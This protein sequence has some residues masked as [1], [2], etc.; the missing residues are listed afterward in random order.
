MTGLDI[1][2]QGDGI[3]GAQTRADVI[4]TEVTFSLCVFFFTNHLIS[5][6]VPRNGPIKRAS[7]EQQGANNHAQ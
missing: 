3:N 4:C 5:H 2:I 1:Q 7:V 6:L